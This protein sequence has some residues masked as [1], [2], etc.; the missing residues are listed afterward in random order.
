[1]IDDSP[2]E[3]TTTE[4]SRGWLKAGKIKIV[5]IR[6]RHRCLSGFPKSFPNFAAPWTLAMA[7]RA[8]RIGGWSAREIS[9]SL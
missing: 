5:S 1:M 4:Q 9:S 8:L 7:S 3:K 2:D 6:D